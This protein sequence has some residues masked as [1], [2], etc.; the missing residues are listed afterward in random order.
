MDEE[1]GDEGGHALA[2]GHALV[3]VIPPPVGGGARSVVCENSQELGLRRCLHR[4]F[5][6]P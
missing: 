4:A 2:G 3:G 6:E 1:R 5:I